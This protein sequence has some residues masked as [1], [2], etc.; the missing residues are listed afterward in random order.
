MS[1]R[2]LKFKNKSYSVDIIT[3]TPQLAERFLASIK[4]ERNMSRQ[5]INRYR[6]SLRDKHWDSL[7]GDTLCFDRSGHL[8]DG[9]QRCAA[10]IEEGISLDTFVIRGVKADIFFGKDKGKKRTVADS[11]SM[12]GYTSVNALASTLKLLHLYKANNLRHLTSSASGVV[13]GYDDRAAVE[14]LKTH[15]HLPETLPEYVSVHQ[16][17]LLPARAVTSKSLWVFY[18]YLL[19]RI[20]RK[21]ALYFLRGLCGYGLDDNSVMTFLHRRLMRSVKATPQSDRLSQAEQIALINKA[22]SAFCSGRRVNRLRDITWAYDEDFPAFYNA[23]GTLVE[24]DDID[25]S[26]KIS[27]K[28][29]QEK[30]TA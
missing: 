5:T 2:V 28:I 4:L 19:P 12:L 30:A 6:K 18:C 21:T 3:L 22:W 10:V 26:E 24:Y 8:V 14:L 7:N 11:L 15:V 23:D 9:Q 13:T 29:K 17:Q 27:Q 20:E 16:S 25:W 1:A